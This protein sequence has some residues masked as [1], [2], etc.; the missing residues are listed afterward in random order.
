MTATDE[1]KAVIRSLLA[2]LDNL[3]LENRWQ[4]RAHKTEITTAYRVLGEERPVPQF[5][6]KNAN[7]TPT[8]S[9]L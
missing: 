4:L 2:V 3:P 8:N 1:Y 6:I 5:L 9:T 7:E